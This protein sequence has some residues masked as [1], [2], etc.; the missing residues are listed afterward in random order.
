MVSFGNLD[1][2]LNLIVVYVGYLLTSGW[3]FTKLA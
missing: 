3:I 1:F 2:I